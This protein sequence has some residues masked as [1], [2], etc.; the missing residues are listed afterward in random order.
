MKRFPT[1]IKYTVKNPEKYVGDINSVISRSS[2]ETKFMRWCDMNKSVELWGSEIQAIQYYS[3][4]DMKMRRYF[5]DFFIKVKMKDCSIKDFIIEIKPYSQTKLPIKGR[6][7]QS[8]FLTESM[9]WQ[10]NQDKWKAAKEWARL[11]NFEFLVFTEYELGIKKGPR[12]D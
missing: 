4:V 12:P 9:T 11:H 1:P 7:R 5:P 3:Q 2:W 6:K 10:V 8:T